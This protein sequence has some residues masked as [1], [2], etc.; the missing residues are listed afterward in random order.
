MI[1]KNF[2]HGKQVC[3]WV[4]YIKG[5]SGADVSTEYLAEGLINAGIRAKL[6][7]FHSC[8]QFAPW[9]LTCIPAPRDANIILTN[10]WNGFAFARFESRLVVVDRLCVHDPAL[11]PYKGF[12]Q[13]IFHNHFVRRFVIASSRCA[14]AVVAVSDYTAD[15]YPEVLGL[16]RPRV[17]LNAVDTD[18]F[19]P[20]DGVRTFPDDRLVRLLFVG[21]LTSRKG[22]DMLV[23]IMQNLGPNYELYYTAG[24]RA[25]DIPGKLPNMHPLGRLDQQQMVKQYQMADL[26]LFPSRGEGLPRAVME[27]LACG[28]PVVA[29]RISSLPEA[30]DDKV[31][32]LCP[33]D[34][35]EYFVNTVIDLVKD[36]TRYMHLS[37]NARKRAVERFSLSRMIEEYIDL[38]KTLLSNSE[39]D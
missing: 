21:N 30:V 13:K 8:F 33:L 4:P 36:S 39:S 20:V 17:I 15:I 19:R 37:E 11:D 10:S 3:V 27:A 12:H 22:A 28:T 25:K 18:F 35:V 6:Q 2:D 34:D 32:R 23:P 29:A 5:G 9:L 16:P 31:G 1:E 7:C 26:L 14:D 24:L 38:F